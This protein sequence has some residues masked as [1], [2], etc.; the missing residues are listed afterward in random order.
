MKCAA[1]NHDMVKKMR[2]EKTVRRL[3]RLPQITAD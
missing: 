1:C 3:R 2:D